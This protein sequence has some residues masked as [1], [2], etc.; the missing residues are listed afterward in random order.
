MA[1]FVEVRVV[2]LFNK[3]VLF[4][5]ES[6]CRAYPRNLVFARPIDTNCN[7]WSTVA[8]STPGKW[9]TTE[10]TLRAGVE[11][12]RLGLVSRKNNKAMKSS[13][14][15]IHVWLS[16][17][18]FSC[19]GYPWESVRMRIENCFIKVWK[20]LQHAHRYCILSHCAVSPNL[21]CCHGNTEG[22]YILCLQ[23]A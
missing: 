2:A 14:T 7:I 3:M 4:Y 16:F 9:R 10:C 13:K 22:V 1:H 17:S 6:D 19:Y 23:I 15:K 21:S 5:L 8:C 11:N 20:S 18:L 12:N